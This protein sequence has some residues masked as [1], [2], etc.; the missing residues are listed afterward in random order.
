MW[1]STCTCTVPSTFQNT[2]F[3]ISLST[4]KNNMVNTKHLK[5]WNSTINVYANMATWFLNHFFKKITIVI[6]SRW[7]T[8]RGAI[9]MCS[10]HL[11]L[12]IIHGVQ[13]QFVNLNCGGQYIWCPIRPGQYHDNI[14][15]IRYSKTYRLNQWDVCVQ[16]EQDGCQYR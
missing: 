13:K 12:C 2:F 7:M 1:S 14:T 15:M 6:F 16:I 4:V 5:T 8:S 9:K 3:S 10:A 11:L